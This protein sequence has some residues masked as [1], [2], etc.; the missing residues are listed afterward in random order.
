MRHRAHAVCALVCTALSGALVAQGT[1]GDTPGAQ[2]RTPYAAP[3]E[4][5]VV[6]RC[7]RSVY[8][9][10]TG[11]DTRG[12]LEQTRADLAADRLGV[13]DD[14][15]RVVIYGMAPKSKLQTLREVIQDAA[16]P[17]GGMT[18]RTV[19]NGDGTQCT[20][21]GPPCVINCCVCSRA[22]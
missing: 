22:R 17:L 6:V 13:D 2:R 5:I 21:A 19:Q 3:C 9:R 11:S 8:P 18:F 1:A 4:S 7:P 12:G 20:C 15:G 10:A 16:P 14:S